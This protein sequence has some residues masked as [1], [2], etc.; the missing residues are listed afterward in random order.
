[1]YCPECGAEYIDGVTDCADCNRPLQNEP[2]PAPEPPG[3]LELVT[4]L[5]T[6]D[7]VRTALVKSMLDNAEIPYI[8]RND[9]L[10]DLFGIGR[11]VPVNPISGPVIFMVPADLESAALDVLSTLDEPVE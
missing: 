3:D 10:Q 6:G 7:A 1:M 5:Q 4:V 9:Q 2:P 11:L 8:A